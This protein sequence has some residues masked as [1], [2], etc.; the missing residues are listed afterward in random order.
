MATCDGTRRHGWLYF[1]ASPDN[2][3]EFRPALHVE[4]DTQ[5]RIFYATSPEFAMRLRS[6]TNRVTRDDSIDATPLPWRSL[7]KRVF[8]IAGSAQF[9]QPD[10]AA[11]PSP[12]RLTESRGSCTAV[13]PARMLPRSMRRPGPVVQFWQAPSDEA[14]EWV[15]PAGRRGPNGGRYQWR[16]ARSGANASMP[17]L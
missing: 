9:Q 12:P 14:A 2:P 10:V 7:L 13:P 17:P 11:M 5:A 6:M 1:P 15:S 3:H 4:M 16:S 8:C